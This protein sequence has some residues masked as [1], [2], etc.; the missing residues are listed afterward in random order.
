MV[1]LLYGYKK[2]SNCR[3]AEQ[4]LRQNKLAYEFIDITE[5]PPNAAQVARISALANVLP[6]KMLNT[7]GEQ[8]RQLN[9]KQLLPTLTPQ[10]I[11]NLLET[12]GRLIKRPLLT[13][14]KRAT[15]GF[16]AEQFLAIW[17]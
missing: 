11:F 3:K 2:C 12:N 14:G 1:I 17:Q 13:D 16:N 7:S 9:V 8:Y 6:Q 4:Y 5:S 15:V 10:E